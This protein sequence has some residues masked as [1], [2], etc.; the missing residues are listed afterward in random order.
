MKTSDLVF[1][2]KLLLLL[3]VLIM[4]DHKE[5]DILAFEWSQTLKRGKAQHDTFF[6]I[7]T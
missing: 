4:I 7:F 5:A 6:S 1:G 3:T 2:I